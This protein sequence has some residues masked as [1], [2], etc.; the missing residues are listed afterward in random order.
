M[1]SV[2]EAQ[3]IVAIIAGAVVVT[4]AITI[5]TVVGLSMIRTLRADLNAAALKVE[6]LTKDIEYK[7][8][9]GSRFETLDDLMKPYKKHL[10]QS[11]FDLQ[12]RLGVQ[13]GV[14]GGPG[15]FLNTFKKRGAD[16]GAYAIN[17]TIYFFAEFL[18]WLEVI[19]R[20]VVFVTGSEY[21]ESLN[22]LLDS[23]RYQLTGE[24]DVQGC[25][26]ADL[27]ENDDTYDKHSKIMQLYIVDIRS[28]GNA[29]LTTVDNL[30]R[31]ITVDVFLQRFEASDAPKPGNEGTSFTSRDLREAHSL[32]GA[33]GGEKAVDIK[34][35]KKIMEPLHKHIHRLSEIEDPKEAPKRRLAILQVL[36]CKL[37]A[38]LD[39]AVPWDAGPKFEQNEE[40]RYIQRDIRLTPAV[41]S[42]SNKQKQFLR[43]QV[44]FQDDVNFSFPGFREDLQ[45]KTQAERDDALWP[46]ACPPCEPNRRPD[47]YKK[48]QPHTQGAA[49]SQTVRRRKM[50]VDV[51]GA[52]SGGG[53]LGGE[54]GKSQGA[55]ALSHG[56]HLAGGRTSRPSLGLGG[57]GGLFGGSNPRS[58]LAN[59]KQVHPTPASHPFPSM[60][61]PV[62]RMDGAGGAGAGEAGRGSGGS[63][64]GPPRTS[65]TVAF[66]EDAVGST[67]GTAA[68]FAG[69]RGNS[70]RPLSSK[71]N[72]L[73]E[74]VLAAEAGG[75]E[76]RSRQASLPGTALS[77]AQVRGTSDLVISPHIP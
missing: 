37:I 74:N 17:S 36:L 41:K 50:Q 12:S 40:P 32:L 54:G 34:A 44:F 60:D 16:D 64:G 6:A 23:I 29:M 27:V 11:A 7:K 73:F 26:K 24:T 56:H 19:R 66:Q 35:F 55:G 9:P 18:G 31:P 69:G 2:A 42:L 45:K 28:I 38:I 30:V 48:A 20:Q 5:I 51:V 25:S 10:L 47:Y 61:M 13:L 76:A 22:S 57:G 63:S 53:K 58:A 59:M 33:G 21:A 39:N 70:S 4:A 68:G 43:D 49:V 52:P 67:A 15:G 77:A 46:G 65:H 71:K 8:G 62:T 72:G 14:L 1:S 3:T 75:M